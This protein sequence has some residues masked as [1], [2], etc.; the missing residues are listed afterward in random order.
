MRAS[1]FVVTTGG[2]LAC[3][4]TSVVAAPVDTPAAIVSTVEKLADSLT[5]S[6]ISM[7]LGQ[8]KPLSQAPIEEKIAAGEASG[9]PYNAGGEAGPTA[10]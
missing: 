4:A 9:F 10:D 3:L 5:V 6:E 7:R 2:A 1:S 8:I